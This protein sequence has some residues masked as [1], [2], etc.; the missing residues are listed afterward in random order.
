[1]KKILF[2]LLII[3]PLYAQETSDITDLPITSEI[4]E[5]TQANEPDAVET[6]DFEPVSHLSKSERQRIEMELKTSTLSELAVWARTLGLSESG[7]REELTKRIRNYYN[8]PEPSQ[9]SAANQ[10]ILTIESAQT[11]D[12]F[13]IDAVNE[14]YARLRGD[15]NISLKDG[16]SIHTIKAD[17]I[18]F[19]RT[20]NILT[21]SGNVEYIKVDGDKTETFR[22]ESITV[23]I[24]NW[25]SIFLD[26]SSTMKDGDTA[27]LF[28]GKIISRTD[29]DV[30]ILSNAS[31]TSASSGDEAYWSLTAS[32]L[33]LLPGSD[34]AIF[35]AV[36]KVGEIPVLY[37]PFFYFPTDQLVF[38]PVIGTRRREGSF[39][40]T[41]TYILGQ[42]KAESAKESS[43]S[44]ILGN[45]GDSQLE[46]EG[47]FLRATGK[48]VVNPNEISLK[49]MVDYY[50]KL[51]LYIG[52][53]LGIPKIGIMNTLNLSVGLG[54][55]RTVYNNDGEY[56]PYNDNESFDT[57]ESNLFSVSVPFRYRLKFGS[58]I[59]GKYGSLVWDFPYYSDPYTD[60]DFVMN[61]AE[62]MDWAK[63]VMEGAAVEEAAVDESYASPYIWSLSGSLS[64]SLPKLAP[65]LQISSQS[66]SMS[67]G[68]VSVESKPVDKDKIPIPVN[69]EDPGRYFYAPSKYT[70]YSYSG[71]I[72]GNP[73]SLGG[74]K[75]ASGKKSEKQTPEEPLLGIGTPISPWE[76]SETKEK[77]PQSSDNIT[78]PILRQSFSLPSLGNLKFTLDYT[79][80]PTSFSELQFWNHDNRWNTFEKVDWTEIHSILTS[81]GGSAD[82]TLRF[83]H[84]SG[85][86]SNSVSFKGQGLW[87]DYAFLNEDAFL[88]KDGN[89]DNEKIKQTRYR[90]YENTNY[91][92]SYSY[93]GKISP[94]YF[95]QIFKQTNF[96]YTFG[97]SLVKNKKYKVGES[98]E[99]GPELTP[100]WGA[101]VKEEVSKEIYGLNN[102]RIAANLNANILD[103]NQSLTF[104]ATLPPLDETISTSATLRFWNST[105]SASFSMDR[106]TEN[107]LRNYPDKKIDEWI[108][109]PIRLSETLNFFPIVNLSFSMA[110]D[111]EKDYEV[112][113]TRAGLKFWSDK[114]ELSFLANKIAKVKFEQKAAGGKWEEEGDPV[115][116]PKS[117][118][119][120]Y[121]QTF[122]EIKIYKDWL[123]LSFLIRTSLSFNLHKYTE[124]NFRFTFGFTFKI[125]NF[126]DITFS[127][128]SNN[129]V[130][131]RYFKGFSGL[132]ELTFMY[133]EGDQNNLFIDLW[134]SFSFWDIAKR[135]RSGFK[136]KGFDLTVN[137]Y[138][139]DWTAI[140][141]MNMKPY[142]DPR[143]TDPFKIIVDFS[144]Y[145][146]WKPIMEIKSGMKHDGQT[147]KWSKMD[148]D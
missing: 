112:T 29:Q 51:G 2:L 17:E 106:A 11:T 24:D 8:I 111:P 53:D 13:K 119:L 3:P 98:P 146:Q 44:R 21:A 124:S 19:N 92:S 30:T 83:E 59:S 22:G 148:L 86:F 63:M 132:E 140:L 84:T 18:L 43:L 14:D 50:T 143:T 45:S 16:D 115:L 77:S 26:G 73:L 138:M 103:N 121:S 40:Q 55:T 64:P 36:L 126:L 144:F 130:I 75:S 47:L 52:V 131:W 147:E 125:R 67:L 5:Q 32:R 137:H 123:T 48:K 57:N 97:G 81:V 61:R 127:A 69:P 122:N 88:D 99:D 20:R 116:H 28:S 1:M 31:I 113:E 6:E 128:S 109:K 54:F 135:E 65:Y 80:S 108:L 23:N 7:T 38:H 90:Q 104:S 94:F 79:I 25:S 74:A 35:N 10:K 136:M 145:V 110:I 42:P 60:R 82:I 46:R 9:H 101:W 89:L 68:F 114:I 15:V 58:S 27:Y 100:I 105:T 142:R 117:L 66:I 141:T 95:D 93:A 96:E 139:G 102:H 133:P 37:I 56:T 134:D 72:R 70:I 76:E 78:P 4:I 12:Y 120:S 62:S 91:Q 33:L 39:I 71:S 118:D 34:F 49:A 87:R 85:L 129:D 41:T 107:S